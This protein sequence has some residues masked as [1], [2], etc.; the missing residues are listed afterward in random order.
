MH[1]WGVNKRLTAKQERFVQA[2]VSGASQREAYRAAY[3]CERSSD[4]TVDNKAYAL[5]KQGGIRARYDELIAE[6]ASRV[7]WDRQKAAET[8]LKLLAA[9]DSKVELSCQEEAASVMT[10]DRFGSLVTAT[11]KRMPTDIPK[12]AARAMVLAVMELNR[13]FDVYSNADGDDDNVTIVID[14]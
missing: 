3:N 8:L 7:L 12:S 2:L 1:P 10:A 11:V 6:L 5:F 9:S 4:K 13:M 14:V